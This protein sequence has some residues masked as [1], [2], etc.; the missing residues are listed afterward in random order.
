MRLAGKTVLVSAGPTRELLDPVRYISNFSSGK[1]GYAIAK[2]ALEM[3]AQVILVSGPVSIAAPE[4]AK[5]VPIQ[6]T[7][8]LLDAMQ[9]YAPKADIVIQSAAPADYRPKTVSDQK[10]KK[11]DGG[12][13]V[14]ELVENP[15][16]AATIGKNKRDDQ[17]F[18]VFAAETQ[19]LL[20]N[21]AGKLRR[22]N[23]DFIVANDVS[24]PGAGFHVDT[25]IATI[26]TETDRQE[27]PLMQKEALAQ[28]ILEKA[29][30]LLE[31][32]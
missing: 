1:M 29:A 23:A 2:R 22:K 32:K 28:I 10:I 16:V 5:L 20:E 17:I 14:I 4:G 19:N 30:Q 6:S 11:I 13:L 7:L 18:V 21:A 9:T 3:G 12:N 25:N 24:K 15:D 8:D 27:Y 26:L 31:D